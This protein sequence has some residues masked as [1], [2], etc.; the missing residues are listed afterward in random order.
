MSTQPDTVNPND[1]EFVKLVAGG[2]DFCIEVARVRE[3]RRWSPVT[4]LPHAPEW[5]LGVMNLRGA[6]VPIFDLAMKLG[7]GSTAITPRHVVMIVTAS[8]RTVGLLVDAVAEIL[9]ASDEAVSNAP[10]LPGANARLIQ[11]MIA[12]SEEA[13]CI[14]DVDAVAP[15][16]AGA[17]P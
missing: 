13:L 12:L 2:Q 17:A 6:V 14:L 4:P 11:G 15:V 9:K 10:P 7:L 5:L 8:D 16:L 1:I 3:I